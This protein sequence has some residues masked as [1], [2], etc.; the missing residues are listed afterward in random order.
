MS[1]HAAAALSAIDRALGEVLPCSTHPP[2]IWCWRC[3]TG[4]GT[5]PGMMCRPCRDYMCGESD[6]DPKAARSGGTEAR[7][8][9]WPVPRPAQG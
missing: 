5:A 6:D 3:E 8:R 2:S 1:R 7:H 4:R 9:F